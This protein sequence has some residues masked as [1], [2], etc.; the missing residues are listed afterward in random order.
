VEIDWGP[1]SGA[2]DG[3]GGVFREALGDATAAILG[4]IGRQLLEFL[5]WVL[6]QSVL[7][8]LGGAVTWTLR[9]TG[10]ALLP[11]P[12]NWLFFTPRSMTV[13]LPGMQ[14][15]MLLAKGGALMALAPAIGWNGIALMGG[16]RAP[17]DVA[18]TLLMGVF[19]TVLSDQLCGLSLDVLNA[20]STLFVGGIAF[21]G[22]AA[23]QGIADQ[24]AALPG[25]AATAPADPGGS[26]AALVA[27]DRTVARASSELVGA[28]FAAALYVVVAFFSAAAGLLRIGS[29]D[30]LLVLAPLG[31]AGWLVPATQRFAL[32]WTTAWATVLGVQW[33]AN[34][35]LRGMTEFVARGIA[36][37]DLW[38]IVA[39]V[40]AGFSV[41]VF[42]TGA[43]IFGGFN[44][45]KAT[46]TAVRLAR[47]G[48]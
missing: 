13:D 16:R 9:E 47:A 27:I 1:L 43:S 41:V 8:V 48:T 34:L 4:G 32:G 26:G 19:L 17:R 3:L 44:L 37:G 2:L 38:Q 40:A 6:V 24:I 45:F 35:L 10:G 18:E 23:A 39:G 25:L 11:G 31:L 21:P 46:Q 5:P 42:Y 15:L 30:A 20:F 14:P 22:Q 33:P 12:D 7:F 28:G 29:I 36:S